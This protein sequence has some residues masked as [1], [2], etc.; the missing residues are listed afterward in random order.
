VAVKGPHA[1]HRIPPPD[2]LPGLATER[3]RQRLNEVLSR[4][5]ETEEDVAGVS[6]RLGVARA[7]QCL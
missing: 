2:S 1:M 4:G 3:I 5:L 7:D 6:F